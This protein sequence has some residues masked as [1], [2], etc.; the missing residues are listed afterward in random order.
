MVVS[1]GDLNEVRRDAGPAIVVAELLV[2]VK[3]LVEKRLSVEKKLLVEVRMVSRSSSSRGVRS[4]SF[5]RKN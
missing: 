4:Q 2:Q 5:R 3:L 1:V